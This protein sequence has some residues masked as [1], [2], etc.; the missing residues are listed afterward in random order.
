MR[1]K[2]RKR[3][4]LNIPE[5]SIADIRNIIIDYCLVNRKF[6]DVFRNIGLG[7]ERTFSDLKLNMSKH[8][9]IMNIICNNKILHITL[10]A[11]NV[12]DGILHTGLCYIP[13]IDIIN[14]I[15]LVDSGTFGGIKET[16][17]INIR[18]LMIEYIN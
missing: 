3:L 5:I 4:T 13:I 11:P 16:G 10:Y 6:V 9:G 8:L 14:V 12:I 1:C 18:G 17:D 2:L 15:N 7:K